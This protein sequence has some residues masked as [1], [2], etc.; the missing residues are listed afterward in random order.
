M[1]LAES[2]LFP[3]KQSL[4]LLT[5]LRL[6]QNEFEA[7]HKHARLQGDIIE[8]LATELKQLKGEAGPA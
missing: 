2:D 4:E 5:A 7:M 8:A 3:L 6:K 1:Q